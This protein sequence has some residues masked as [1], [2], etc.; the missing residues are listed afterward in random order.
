M[1][2]C[3]RFEEQEQE[4][5]KKKQKAL[6]DFREKRHKI[7]NTSDAP[8]SPEAAKHSQQPVTMTTTLMGHAS[9]MATGESQSRPMTP[10]NPSVILGETGRPPTVSPTHEQSMKYQQPGP[11]PMASGNWNQNVGM[12]RP[13]VP[14]GH[15]PPMDVSYYPP[16]YPSGHGSSHMY[17]VVQNVPSQEWPSQ[18]YGH[19]LHEHMAPPTYHVQHDSHHGNTHS[20]SLTYALGGPQQV[21]VPNSASVGMPNVPMGVSHPV[22]PHQI[23]MPHN[24]DG[25]A[26]LPFD[27]SQTEKR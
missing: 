14:P 21:G 9:K 8:L 3:N 7:T 17:P 5:Q 22:A 1:L 25:A 24:V 20:S 10:Y 2:L 26:D 16:T 23:G 27:Q 13:G 4:L 19:P 18:Y 12:L 6:Q 11:V 15:R